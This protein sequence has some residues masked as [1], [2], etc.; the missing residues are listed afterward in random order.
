MTPKRFGASLEDSSKPYFKNN[1]V[2]IMRLT[3]LAPYSELETVGVI[4]G[5]KHYP[6]SG[7][8][9]FDFD[10]LFHDGEQI[11]GLITLKD[12]CLWRYTANRDP[13]TLELEAIYDAVYDMHKPHLFYRDAEGAVINVAQKL[14]KPGPDEIDLTDAELEDTP[15]LYTEVEALTLE[16]LNTDVPTGLSVDEFI[17]VKLDALAIRTALIS[18]NGPIPFI[19]MEYIAQGEY[20]VQVV[21]R[22][23]ES[24]VDVSLKYCQHVQVV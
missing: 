16:V 20:D 22:R 12:L 10:T 11:T 21:L 13:S 9:V 15:T 6:N 2:V 1:E 18:D 4:G 24:A 14:G 17:A 3:G 23:G 5:I 7:P 8:H 19:R